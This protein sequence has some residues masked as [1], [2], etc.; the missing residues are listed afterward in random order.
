MMVR[1]AVGCVYRLSRIVF[2]SYCFIFHCR[3]NLCIIF[4]S[5][6]ISSIAVS[7]LILMPIF[8]DQG[9]VAAWYENSFWTSIAEIF[10]AIVQVVFILQQLGVQQPA[11]ATSQFA[12]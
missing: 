1:S 12:D 8:V 5:K 9:P 3:P 7:G 11:S 10:T 4:S 2:D 6:N